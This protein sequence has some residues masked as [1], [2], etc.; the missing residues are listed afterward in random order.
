M[1]SGATIAVL[2]AGCKAKSFGA[3]NLL[4]EAQLLFF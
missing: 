4:L 2:M 3:N 1:T